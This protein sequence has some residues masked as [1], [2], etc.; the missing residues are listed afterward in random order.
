MR[1][2]RSNLLGA[3]SLCNAGYPSGRM[4]NAL[5]SSPPRDVRRG[6][7]VGEVSGLQ[8]SRALGKPGCERADKAIPGAVVRA[9]GNRNRRD[10]LRFLTLRPDDK[11]LSTK[12]D[13]H[14][15]MLG[16]QR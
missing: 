14:V 11:S 13:D 8:E 10:R 2:I 4:Q 9:Y 15:A 5:G 3:N 12:R 1:P 7:P 6:D 16:T